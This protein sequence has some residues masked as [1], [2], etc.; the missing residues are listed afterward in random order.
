MRHAEKA[1]IRGTDLKH[2]TEQVIGNLRKA[3]APQDQAAPFRDR[4]R[5]FGTIAPTSCPWSEEN[6]AFNTDRA[7]GHL[8]KSQRADIASHD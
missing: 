4:T 2:S 8:R 1:G 5:Q 6:G 3:D 7:P